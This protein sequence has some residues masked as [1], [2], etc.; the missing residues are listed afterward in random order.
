M[1]SSDSEDESAVEARSSNDESEN[2]QEEEQL[3]IGA[4]PSPIKSNSF[5]TD[6]CCHPSRDAVA[7]ATV[8]G[9]VV[10]H[11]YAIDAPSHEL[12]SFSHHKH[13]CR[14]V[15]FHPDG[16]LMF[17]A[18]K[19]SSICISDMNTGALVHEIQQAH[20]SPI[21]SLCVIDDYLC[22]TGDDDG[23]VK[24]WDYR[25]QQAIMESTDCDD[26]VSDMAIDPT[27]KT[28]LVTSGDGTLT[29]FNVR[30]KSM[31]LQ[32]E[33]FDEEFL[34]VAIMMRGRKAV[35][36][37]GDGSLSLFNWGE[38]GNLSD[39]FPCKQGQ[40]ID[41]LA[42]V[43]DHV[44]CTGSVDGKIRGVTLFP[45]RYLGVIGSHDKFPIESLSVSHD[46]QLLA[47]CSHDE[48]VRF[49]DVSG[50]HNIHLGKD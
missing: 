19:D 4:S 46:R 40:S 39:R 8:D 28:L 9:D 25:R 33:L 32:S 7:L 1:S 41:C 47:S 29:A 34:S 11:S 23:R 21:Y 3:T 22:A 6:I 15:R 48:T 43:T 14:R 45:N 5:V 31:E 44:L 24:L 49:W 12:L 50:L 36:G 13:P 2:E 20:E 16:T 42:T 10:V 35:V 26:Y 30:K 38:W 37:G 18:A 17:T 27:K